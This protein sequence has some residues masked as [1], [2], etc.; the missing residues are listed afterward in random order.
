MKTYT[1]LFAQDVPH[2]GSVEIAATGDED[3]VAKA[4][5]HW[6]RVQR[7]E[8]PWPLDEAQHDSAVLDR[9]VEINDETG[10]QVAADIRLDR[11][12]LTI[13]PTELSAKLIENAS[14]MHAALEQIVRYAILGLAANELGKQL[15]L[16]QILS[17]ARAVLARATGGAA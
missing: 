6:E 1:A 5:I 11:Y 13:A 12:F 7:G 2:Y 9:I 4:H 17:I 10:R 15:N 8:E 14:A 3:A 16:D